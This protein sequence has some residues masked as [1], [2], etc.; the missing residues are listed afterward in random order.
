M[1]EGFDKDVQF[2]LG[3]VEMEFLLEVTQEAGAEGGVRFW[4]VTLQA[5]GEVGSTATHRVT[6]QLE[7]VAK[8]DAGL[9]IAST[10]L[11]ERPDG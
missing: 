10:R 4:V 3:P 11:T 7:P 5:K 8:T 2:R 6:L 9:K 1:L